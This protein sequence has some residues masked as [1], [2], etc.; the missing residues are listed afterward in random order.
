EHLALLRQITVRFPTYWPGWY[1]YANY[2]VHF[3]PYVG[4]QYEDARAAL[5]RTVQLNPGFV[6]AWEHLFWI[7]GVQRD[8]TRDHQA[9]RE[10]ERVSSTTAYRLNPELITMY[11]LGY[12]LTPDGGTLTST[13]VKQQAQS[14]AGYTGP[15]PPLLL[16]FDF[17]YPGFPRAQTQI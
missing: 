10:V 2:M 12:A 4:T 15:R 3:T 11:R 14:L 9:L 16:G 7:A 17:I 6:S 5:E 13:E 1:D 8:T